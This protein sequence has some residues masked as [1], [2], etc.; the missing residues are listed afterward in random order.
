MHIYKAYFKFLLQSTNQHGVHSPFVFDLVT[1]CFYDKNHYPEY[2]IVDAH[3][4]RLLQNNQIIEVKDFGAG[5]RVFKDNKRKVAAIAKNAGISWFRSKLLFRLVNYFKPKNVLEIGTSVG[6]ATVSMALGNRNSEIIT[7]EGC[8]NTL[9]VA[10]NGFKKLEISNVKTVETEFG[11][12]FKTL[13]SQSFDMIYFDGNHSKNATIQYF[14]QLLATINNNSVWIFDDIHWSADMQQAW[15]F[16]KQHPK[17]K[18]TIDTFYWGLV[19]FRTEQAK[20]HFI[21]RM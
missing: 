6:L 19:F 11:S 13:Q 8:P 18:V 5:S 2:Q 1:K 20:E 16:I 4:K 9:V 21:I 14:E 12:Y 17:V 7:L 10:Q 3:R 15:E